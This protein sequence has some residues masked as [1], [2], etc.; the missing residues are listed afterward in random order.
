M[1]F[2]PSPA[3][4]SVPCEP[5]PSA[6]PTAGTFP[7]RNVLRGPAPVQAYD[8]PTVG[9]C[10]LPRPL[11]GFSR[12]DGWPAYRILII[13]Y[14]TVNVKKNLRGSETILERHRSGKILGETARASV[15]GAKPA[16]IVVP[17]HR[18]SRTVS[19]H[20]PASLMPRYTAHDICHETGQSLTSHTDID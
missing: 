20:E 2:Q 18:G 19:G 14:P 12:H 16:A 9:G 11:T 6:F 17:I 1:S 4:A 5:G 3:N 10:R 7:P 13:H 15:G 8:Q